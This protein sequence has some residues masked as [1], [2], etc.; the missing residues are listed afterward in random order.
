ME[1]LIHREADSWWCSLWKV[2]PHGEAHPWRSSLMEMLPRESSFSWRG[3]PMKKL[4]HGEADSWRSSIVKVLTH[5]EA[6]PWRCS[7]MEQLPHEA[8]LWWNPFLEISTH[9]E[10]YSLPPPLLATALPHFSCLC[11]TQYVASASSA[12]LPVSFMNPWLIFLALLTEGIVG[13]LQCYG[14]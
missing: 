6:H 7:L 5:G 3:S 2:L 10:A 14:P 4:T 8:H 11:W 9:G 13:F 1:K 12:F